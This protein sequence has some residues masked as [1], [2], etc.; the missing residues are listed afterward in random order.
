[1][2]GAQRGIVGRV[3]GGTALVGAGAAVVV[4]EAVG[5]GV[6]RLAVRSALGVGRGL[7]ST[8]NDVGDGIASNFGLDERYGRYIGAAL[9]VAATGLLSSVVGANQNGIG[10]LSTIVA[11][12]GIAYGILSQGTPSQS[13]APPSPQPS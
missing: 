11:M 2:R 13:P 9:G 4:P 5:N 3:A 7:A 12:I 1:M 10:T 8:F 6:S